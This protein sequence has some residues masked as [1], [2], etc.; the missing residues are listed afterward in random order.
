IDPVI[1]RVALIVATV[2]GGFGV[3]LYVLGW[4]FLPDE[5]DDV[6]AVEALFGKGRSS[7]PAHVTIGLCIALFPASAWAFG[8][9]W[10]QGTGFA[11]TALLL[12]GLFV[13]HRNRGGQNRPTA[14]VPSHAAAASFSAQQTTLSSENST[15]STYQPPAGVW[16]PLGAE[17]LGWQLSGDDPTSGGPPAPAT[18]GGSPDRSPVPGRRSAGVGITLGATLVTAG[19][20]TTLAMTDLTWFTPA[21]VIGMTLAVLGIGMVLSAL[22][23]S[24]RGLL[25]LAA[26]LSVA[27]LLLSTLPVDDLPG[28]GFGELDARP[29]SAAAVLP[30]YERTG[31]GVTLDLTDLPA[32]SDPVATKVTVGMGDATVL[33]PPDADVTF[34]CNTSMGSLDCLGRTAEGAGVDAVA[35]T[36]VVDGDGPQI[37]LD[38]TSVMGTVEVNRGR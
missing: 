13:L 20:G 31:G 8:D 5:R 17:P 14:R 23:G 11:M 3:L 4:L 10:F 28:G 27:G 37:T 7:T 9:W 12:I 1:V 6:S 29:T 30:E 16:D 34:T 33:V 19:V 35:D 15:E 38:V 36:D 18:G 21:H 22:S 32:D 26:P 25:V 24:G 2:L